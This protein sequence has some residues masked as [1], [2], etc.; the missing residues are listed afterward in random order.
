MSNQ[1]SKQMFLSVLIAL[2]IVAVPAY[3]VDV[4]KVS[5]VGGGSQI[6]FEVEDYDER[7]PD[8]DEYYPVVDKEDAFGQVINRTGVAGG[9][10]SWTFDISAAGGEAGTWYFWARLINPN[11]TSDFMVVAGHPGDEIVD[12]PPFEAG[13]GNDKR[14]FEQSQGPPWTWGVNP[15][16]EGH[17]KELQDGEN[18]MYIY[19]RQGDPNIF[20]DTFM[21][22]DD[23]DYV[24]TDDDYQNALE[25]SSAAVLPAD[26]IAETWGRIKSSH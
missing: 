25:T 16:K 5:N 13:F 15:S 1:I 3:A 7:D 9:M 11:N 21:W 14:I 23:P 26:K 24:P 19:H 17:I 10:I 22:T 18:T 2:L 4:F 12:G 6:W 8:T 20:W